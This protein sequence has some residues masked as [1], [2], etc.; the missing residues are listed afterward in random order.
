[1][2]I[3][4]SNYVNQM[5]MLDFPLE[6]QIGISTSMYQFGKEENK[7]YDELYD[8]IIIQNFK[9]IKHINFNKIKDVKFL[10]ITIRGCPELERIQSKDVFCPECEHILK[11]CDAS[12]LREVSWG[13]GIACISF[14][15]TTPKTAWIRPYKESWEEWVSRGKVNPYSRYYDWTIVDGKDFQK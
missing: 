9:T 13:T 10:K 8:E 5:E 4:G 15:G 14:E 1:M 11:V 2:T 6:G 3:D 12:N 7:T